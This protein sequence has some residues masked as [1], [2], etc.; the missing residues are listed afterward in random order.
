MKPENLIVDRLEAG[1]A[2]C[3]L[4]DRSMTVVAA[5]ELPS[6]VREGDCLR[7]DN[8]RYVVDEAET[9]RRRAA[10]RNLLRSLLADDD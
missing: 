3:E 6:G 1:F 4:P 2:A 7:L 8:G 5:A 9:A 10:N